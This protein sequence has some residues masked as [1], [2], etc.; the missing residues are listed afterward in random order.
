MMPRW[1]FCL[2]G[3]ILVLLSCHFL[4]LASAQI[5]H[6]LE[7]NALQAVRRALK[8]TGKNL[9]SWKK[10]D[11]CVSDWTGVICLM[12]PNDG[13]LHVQELRLLNMKLSGKLAPALGLFSHMTVFFLTSFV[14]EFYVEQFNR[15]HTQG[16]R[17]SDYF[18][19]SVSIKL[20]AFKSSRFR[21][22]MSFSMRLH[23]ALG[24]AKGIIYLHKEADPP[25]IHRDIKANNI[26]DS[27]FTAKVSDLGISKLVPV[28][29]DAGG[30]GHVFTVVRGTP[31]NSACQSGMMYSVIDNGMGPYSSE[32][33]RRFMAL[34]LKCCE[35]E[36]ER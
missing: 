10:T 4:Q 32:C 9:N 29:S 11:P 16:D 21:N 33:L 26:F 1:R 34:A 2:I 22:P 7:V 30:E 23:I 35:D 25:I 5:T 15:Q 20:Q 14:Q 31:V 18:K 28:P 6:P 27:K 13:Y 17:Q 3:I 8:D 24:L 36:T 19:A 12:D